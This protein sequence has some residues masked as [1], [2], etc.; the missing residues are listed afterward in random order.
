MLFVTVFVGLIDFIDDYLKIKNKNKDGL[1]G[2]FK[3]IGQIIIGIIV[4][5]IIITDDSIVVR[6]FTESISQENLKDGIE[7]IDS[8]D[9]ITTIPFVKDNEFNYK[10]LLPIFRKT[11]INFRIHEVDC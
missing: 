4:S 3:I 2:R 5:Y 6:N 7:Y 8:K 1:K 11:Y 10:W 9:L